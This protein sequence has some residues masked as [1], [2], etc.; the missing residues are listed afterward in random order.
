MDVLKFLNFA[1]MLPHDTERL[2][3]AIISGKVLPGVTETL[4]KARNS[5][6]AAFEPDRTVKTNFEGKLLIKEK[7]VTILKEWAKSEACWLEGLPV[8]A[9]YLTRGGESQVYQAPDTHFVLKLNDAVYYATW[10]EYLDSLTIHNILFP[11]TAYE[12][13]GFIEIN[14]QLYALLSQ[15]AILTEGQAA[16]TDI[17]KWLENNGFTNTKGNDY[18][19]KK[20]G[21]ILEDMHD[22]NVLMMDDL[23]FFIDTVFY[24]VDPS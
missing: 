7:Q 4:L 23:L 16:L 17:R 9:M 2:L 11:D 12:L 8:G 6:C 21:L 19:H 14:G 1:Q 3:K 5:L 22:E 24:I 15:P 20:L 18:I 10:L 13:L